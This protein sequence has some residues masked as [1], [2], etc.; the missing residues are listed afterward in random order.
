MKHLKKDFETSR[1]PDSLSSGWDPE[2]H[3]K[4]LLNAL[5]EYGFNSLKNISNNASMGFLGIQIN[6]NEAIDRVEYI[7]KFYENLISRSKKKN[8]DGTELSS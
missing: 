2:V 4:N 3:D 8:T 6:Q 1:I 7:C 5:W